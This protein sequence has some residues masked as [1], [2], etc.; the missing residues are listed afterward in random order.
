VIHG[1]TLKPLLRALHLHDNDPVSHE[2]TLARQRALS[3]GL[4]SF[5]AD[6][7]RSAE[8]ARQAFSERL[9]PRNPGGE[10][11]DGSGPGHQHFYRRAVEAARSAVLAMRD[12]DEIGDDAFHLLEEELD[13]LEMALDASTG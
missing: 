11:A 10:S 5:A 12:N 6:S 9:E 13:R 4:A 1:L 2:V 7:S 3:A 8:V